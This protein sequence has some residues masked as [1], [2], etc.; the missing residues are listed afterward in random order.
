MS[1]ELPS[2]VVSLIKGN[3][4]EYLATVRAADAKADIAH[5]IKQFGITDPE[6][7]ERVAARQA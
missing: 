1:K 5:V 2:W 4:P 7:V 6:R 3:K